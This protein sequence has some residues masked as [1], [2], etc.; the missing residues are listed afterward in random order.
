M[1]CHAGLVD[2]LLHAAKQQGIAA[3]CEI[4]NDL[5]DLFDWRGMVEII[6]MRG[7]IHSAQFFLW[8]EIERA[9]VGRKSASAVKARESQKSAES[10][11][12]REAIRG[13]ERCG[14]S[15][16]FYDISF[17]AQGCVN[18]ESDLKS[19]VASD[20]SQRKHSTGGFFEDLEAFL[21]H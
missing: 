16:G 8:C 6:E 2:E 15:V 20:L 21:A 18:L 19:V 4:L 14:T 7:K 3:Q 1:I 5:V 12:E 9:D 17:I 13:L 10:G 11:E